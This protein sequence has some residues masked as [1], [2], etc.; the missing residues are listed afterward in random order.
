MIFTFVHSPV[1]NL[2]S[3]SKKAVFLSVMFFHFLTISEKKEKYQSFISYFLGLDVRKGGVLSMPFSTGLVLEVRLL[4]EHIF[5][6]ILVSLIAG[7]IGGLRGTGSYRSPLFGVDPVSI[8]GFRDRSRRSNNVLPMHCCCRQVSEGFIINKSLSGE[9]CGEIYLRNFQKS[10]ITLQDHKENV[11]PGKKVRN[12]HGGCFNVSQ[13]YLS[14]YLF[15]IPPIFLLIIHLCLIMCYDSILILIRG[16]KD[17]ATQ[18]EPFNLKNFE[19]QSTI[20]ISQILITI[21]EVEIV[22]YSWSIAIIILKISIYFTIKLMCK[23]HCSR[24]QSDNA[25]DLFKIIERWIISKDVLIHVVFNQFGKEI[26]LHVAYQNHQIFI[27]LQMIWS[28]FYGIGRQLK[29]KKNKNYHKLSPLLI[30]S[31]NSCF[32]KPPSSGDFLH[33]PITLKIPSA[34]L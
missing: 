28:N 34:P 2:L 23:D 27:Q 17:D 12:F 3:Q 10:Q 11:A 21:I 8:T 32:H 9:D 18:S 14:F 20:E 7:G 25:Q 33:G 6:L 15:C 24:S 31:Y 22:L 30:Y 19:N 1:S 13:S 5:F 4:L 26:I 16:K 29:G